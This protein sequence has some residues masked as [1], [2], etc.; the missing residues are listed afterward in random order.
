LTRL[1][2]IGGRIGGAQALALLRRHLDWPDVQVR[3]QILAALSQCGYRAAEV[4]KGYIHQAMKAEVAQAART[5]A[6]LVDLE[7]GTEAEEKGA[8]Q[9]LKVALNDALARQRNRLFLWLSFVYDAQTILQVRDTLA[10]AASGN[11][12][13]SRQQQDYA[14]EIMDVLIS[15]ELKAI[16]GPL[17]EEQTPAQRLQRLTSLFPQPGLTSRERLSEIIG[18]PATWLAPWTKACALYA[19]GQL[20]AVELS[21]AVITALDDPDA[22]ARESAVW[23]LARLDAILYQRYVATLAQDSSPLVVQAIR[24]LETETKGGTIMFT[25][26]EKVMLLKTV[27][28]FAEVSE[29]VL[30]EAAATLAELEVKA[31]ETILAKDERNSAM[32]LIVE[33]QVSLQ[34]GDHNRATLG[35][36]EVFGE[37]A[38]LNPA[39]QSNPITAL[40]DAR[41]LRLDQAPLF[42]LL[43]DHPPLAW[44]IIQ[45]LAQRLQRAG[46][47]PAEQARAD[48]LGGLKEKLSTRQGPGRDE[49][50]T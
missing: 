28:F 4:D 41:L 3:S 13:V 7:N 35:E 36:G 50:R 32:Y 5:L 48:L 47:G 16:L 39:P 11:G 10:G 1:A 9:L 21:G 2:R 17:I 42:E 37:L 24:S 23:T 25:L 20:A 29:E 43:E 26:V 22:L 34:N 31:G 49:A 40:T 46:Q 15:A 38:L 30:A 44:A 6:S 45:R 12:R 33:G 27:D 8:V 19:V 14:L 18:Q